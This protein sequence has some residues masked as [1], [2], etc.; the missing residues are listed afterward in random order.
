MGNR[1]FCLEVKDLIFRL[2]EIIK[3]NTNFESMSNNYFFIE[4]IE[5]HEIEKWNIKRISIINR[6]LYLYIIGRLS[7]IINSILLILIFSCNYR[8]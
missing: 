8:T 7:A 5:F 2:P 3:S 4:F 6:I 1:I